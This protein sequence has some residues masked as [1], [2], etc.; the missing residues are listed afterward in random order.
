MIRVSFNNAAGPLE[1]RD[2]ATP[3]EAAAVAIRMIQVAGV[4]C[5]DDTITVAEIEDSQM[6]RVSLNNAAGPLITRDVATPEEAAEVAI[7]MI[8]V[9]GVLY[10]DDTI[11]VAEIED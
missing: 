4:L 10:E 6:I 3:E 11:T 9:A 2:V 1:T 7:R 5:E 8:Q